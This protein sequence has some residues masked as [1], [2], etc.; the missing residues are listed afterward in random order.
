MFCPVCRSEY[1]EGFYTCSDCQVPLV[2]RIPEEDSPVAFH[3]LWSGE[4]AVF[5]DSLLDELERAKIGATA[6]PRHVLYR[7]STNAL[8]IKPETQFAFAVC[9]QNKDVSAAQAIL[10]RLL[11]EEPGEAVLQAES[12]PLSQQESV[13]VAELP[14]N[15][16]TAPATALAW[17][18]SDEDHATFVEKSL[19]GVGIPTLRDREGAAISVFV[20]RED[21]ARSQEV[22]REIETRTPPQEDLWP[23]DKYFWQDEPVQSYRLLWMVSVPF[24][25][26][27]LLSFSSETSRIF[28]TA[29]PIFGLFGVA[30][31]IGGFWMLYQ[32]IRYE[33]RPLRFVIVAMTL[34]LSFIWYYVERYAKRSGVR[35]L[36][37]A[38]RMRMPPPTSA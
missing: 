1:R 13:V 2:A 16:N 11:E 38:V 3:V 26:L 33:V 12:I 23:R 14:D 22:V 5:M 32:A 8:G 30:A 19:R 20:H 18:G 9:V 36:P 4:N 35:R 25:F 28:S 17:T 21:E 34:P 7:N 29:S 27:V 10:E 24:L 6:I 37:I 31:S 15:W